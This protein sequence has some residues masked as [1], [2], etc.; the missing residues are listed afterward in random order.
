MIEVLKH[1]NFKNLFIAGS[2]SEFGSF[3]TDTALMLYLFDL[4]G[5][6]KSFLGLSKTSFMVML[7]IGTILG[8]PIGEKFRRRNVLLV[9]EF[10]RI[11]I[12]LGI[13][14]SKNPYL[15]VVLNGLLAFFTGMF[16]PSRQTMTNDLLTDKEDIKKANNLFSSFEAGAHILGPL[17]GATIYAQMKSIFPVISIDALTYIIGIWLLIRVPIMQKYTEPSSETYIESTLNGFK[18]TLRRGDLAGLMTNIAFSGFGMG[19]FL[20]LMLP[21]TKEILLRGD[22]EY[23]FLIT[24]F[25]I[26]G[27][28]GGLI[29][30]K[31]KTSGKSGMILYCLTSI[32]FIFYTLW[33]NNSNYY[34]AIIIALTWGIAVFMRFPLQLSYISLS[35][36]DKM[37]TRTHALKQ[38]AFFMPNVLGTLIVTFYADQVDLVTLLNMT[39]ITLFSLMIF[40]FIIGTGK[41]LFYSNRV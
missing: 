36:E 33:N 35:V 5:G 31:I 20:P 37:L 13:L 23:G 19:I 24:L 25:G 29:A 3:I 39:S 14:F 30:S 7:T 1:K 16:H 11:P 34:M 10:V 18:Y 4:T 41:N 8:G 9:C 17:I 40:R 21:F 12:I 26:G 27:V 22:Q 28:V 32:E 6:Q 15:L 38:I 2:I